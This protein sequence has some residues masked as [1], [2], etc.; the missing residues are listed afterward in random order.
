MEGR[1]ASHVAGKFRDLYRPA[2]LAN[3]QVWPLAQVRVLVLSAAA[4]NLVDVH[5]CSSSTFA[6]C[7]CLTAFHSNKLAEYFGTFTCPSSTQSTYIGF[8]VG[9][10]GGAEAN[11]HLTV[12]VRTISRIRMTLYV[13]HLTELDRALLIYLSSRH[14]RTFQFTLFHVVVALA[15]S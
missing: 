15:F 2:M 3:W 11:R 12:L 5:C 6:S 8:D 4:A 9:R 14:I 10:G 13:A 1:D 7:R